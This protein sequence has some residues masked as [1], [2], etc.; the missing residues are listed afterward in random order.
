MLFS[1]KP[2]YRILNLVLNVVLYQPEIP[3]NTGAIARTCALIETRL[4]LVRPFGFQLLD[5]RMKRASMDY[6]EDAELTEHASWQAFEESLAPDA[7]VFVL[8][9]WASEIY[10]QIE[11]QKNDYLVFGRESDGV[12][13]E[14][15]EKYRTLRIPMPGAE[16]AP[17]EDHR[18]HSLNLSVSV[19][20]AAFEAARQ[21]SQNWT[22][23]L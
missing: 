18:F 8:S 3:H 14:I 5:K 11:Y 23:K 15:L 16:K 20:I 4:H 6:L 7:R 22:L 12:P 19:G 13:R 1:P 17:R 2:K 10:S 21:I 9:G